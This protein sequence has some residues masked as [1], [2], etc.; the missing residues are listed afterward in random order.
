[1]LIFLIIFHIS[2]FDQVVYIFISIN[3]LFMLIDP[4]LPFFT[5]PFFFYLC[6]HPL[7][8]SFLVVLPLLVEG[9]SVIG[10]IFSKVAELTNKG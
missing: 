5:N 3:F 7:S 2:L 8:L 9:F 1:M 4:N 10:D 6:P